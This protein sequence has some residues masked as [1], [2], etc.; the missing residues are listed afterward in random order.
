[1]GPPS[2][3]NVS[4]FRGRGRGGGPRDGGVG[5]KNS[6]FYHRRQDFRRQYPELPPPLIQPQPAA[7]FVAPPIHTDFPNDP[8]LKELSKK[9]QQLSAIKRQ[10]ED[11]RRTG[12]A[13]FPL[14]KNLGMERPLRED[15]L[16]PILDSIRDY[17]I[18]KVIGEVE[19]ELATMAIFLTSTVARRVAHL[20]ALP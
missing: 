15:L 19:D 14:W 18:T 12:P 16:I 11:V 17:A 13:V 4:N 8:N 6:D 10:L 7:H 9:K 2:N 3:S 1:M 20:T 5:K